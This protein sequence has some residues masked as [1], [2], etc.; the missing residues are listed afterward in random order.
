MAVTFAIRGDSLDARYSSAGKSAGLIGAEPAAVISDATGINGV[1]VISLAGTVLSGRPMIFNGAGN[2][3]SDKARSVLIRVKFSSTATAL[4]GL[5]YVGG[6]ARGTYNY[7]GANLD[8]SAQVRVDVYN[9]LGQNYN[10]T[11]TSSGIGTSAWHDIVITWDGAASNTLLLYVDGTLKNTFTSTRALPTY[12]ANQQRVC[13]QIV[14]GANDPVSSNSHFLL[15]EFVVFDTVID[16]T[17]VTLTSGSDSL[18]G[19]SRTAYVDVAQ[20]DGLAAS[21][22]GGGNAIL[23]AHQGFTSV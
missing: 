2:T 23:G 12:S 13:S 10:S 22:S 1:N 5:F 16:P 3:P 9:E 7:V 8:T 11:G 19:A 20:Y 14:L 17:S 21:G 18:N 6:M 4:Q 15:D